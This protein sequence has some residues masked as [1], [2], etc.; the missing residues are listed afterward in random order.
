VLLIASPRFAEHTTPPGHPER[1]ERAGVFDAVAADVV[2]RGGRVVAPVAATRE[3]LARVHT[4][5][6][7]DQVAATA[8]TASM[9]DPDTFTSPESHEIATLAAGAVLMAARHARA[10]GEPALALVR[11][12]G[13]HAEADRAMGFCLYN[14][15]AI[16][17]AALRAEGIG[18]VAIVDI[19][20]HHGNGT[21]AAFYTDPTVLFISSHQFPYYPGTG[22]ADERGEG[23]GRG[24]TLNLPLDAGATDADFARVYEDRVIPALDA[25]APDVILVSAGYDA[26]ERDPLA[27]MRMTAAGYAHLVGLLDDAAKRLCGRRIALATEGGYHLEALRECLNAT[28]GVLD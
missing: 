27:G 28:I 26:H 13:H 12:P 19:D 21:Q 25:F 1:P 6:Y 14:N 11:P 8:G 20:V 15:I 2:W 5:A 24:F 9:L 17:A 10:T 18:R 7:L 23:A 3:D 4:A 22:A 16:A